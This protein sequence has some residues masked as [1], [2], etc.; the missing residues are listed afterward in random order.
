[1]F[2]VELSNRQ[3]LVPIDEDQIQSAVR[4]VLRGEGVTTARVGIAV[5]DDDTIRQLNR[6]YLNH[7]C[8]TDVLSFELDGRSDG[9]DGDIMISAEMAA[10]TAHQYGWD[11]SDELLLYAVHGT[12]H[13]IGYRDNTDYSRAVMRERECNYL[14]GYGLQPR[15]QQPKGA[16]KR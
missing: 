4:R 14:A 10:M 8:A 1:M 7:D 16:S 2:D 15:Y 6:R 12:L 11:A 5:V 9:L 13:L 3:D